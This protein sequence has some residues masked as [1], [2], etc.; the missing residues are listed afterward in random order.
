MSGIPS[1]T[2]Q[3]VSK[4]QDWDVDIAY[5]YETVELTAAEKDMNVKTILSQI[6]SRY[7]VI[8]K[9][10]ILQSIEVL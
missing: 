8:T 6:T 4:A 3:S 9:N 5:G 1:T 10:K 2:E 7:A